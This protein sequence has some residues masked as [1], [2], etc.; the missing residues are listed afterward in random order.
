MCIFFLIICLCYVVI[1]PFWGPFSLLY[2]HRV[3]VIFCFHFLRDMCACWLFKQADNVFKTRSTLSHWNK[4]PCLAISKY[5]IW[6]CCYC[7]K[8]IKS[9]KWNLK[10]FWAT[11]MSQIDGFFNESARKKTH[12]KCVF[13]LHHI[14]CWYGPFFACCLFIYE[15]LRVTGWERKHSW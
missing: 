8:L 5:F 7:N 4:F 6:S 14:I 11:H 3:Y 13:W 15:K 1:L 10:L 12:A 2:F 9:N